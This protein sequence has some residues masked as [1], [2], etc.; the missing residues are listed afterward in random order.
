MIENDLAITT[1]LEMH[2]KQE[3]GTQTTVTWTT[4]F[5]YFDDKLKN[6]KANS[7]QVQF[8]KSKSSKINLAS[9][10]SRYNPLIKAKLDTSSDSQEEEFKHKRFDK[11]QNHKCHVCDFSSPTKFKV[12]DHIIIHH[13]NYDS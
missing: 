9:K 10:V 4:E 12:D 5:N 8:K 7:K 1:I 6:K 3:M 11:H 2:K 13:K